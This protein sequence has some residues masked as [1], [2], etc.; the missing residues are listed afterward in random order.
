V[1]F[2]AIMKSLHLTYKVTSAAA[3]EQSGFQ[4]TDGQLTRRHG[5]RT[6]LTLATLLLLQLL[7]V[8]LLQPWRAAL[9]G[10]T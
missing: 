4:R 2:L 3:V 7:R 8:L 5:R 10:T 6:A 1:L 9:R